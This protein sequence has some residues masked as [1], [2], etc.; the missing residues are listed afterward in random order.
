MDDEVKLSNKLILKKYSILF[1]ITF[2]IIFIPLF[3]KNL[4]LGISGLYYDSFSQHL[5]F[6]RD[7]IIKI[8]DWLFNGNGFSIYSFNI[9]YGADVIHIYG[10]YSL[11]DPFNIIAIILNLIFELNFK[12][13][14]NVVI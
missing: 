10:Y 6:M 11:F 1:F 4:S 5:L 8:K 13:L 12:I 3:I 14:F 9:G 7:Y 2:L